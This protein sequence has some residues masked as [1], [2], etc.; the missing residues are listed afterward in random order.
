M[1]KLVGGLTFAVVLLAL[2]WRSTSH[3]PRPGSF[4]WIYRTEI[5]FYRQGIWDVGF[6][7]GDSGPENAGWIVDMANKDD[8]SSL[9]NNIRIVSLTLSGSNL[10]DLSPLE[11]QT[12]L[13]ELAVQ[14]CPVQDLSPLTNLSRLHSLDL[15]GTSIPNVNDLKNLHAL[16]HL[17]LSNT[18]ITDISP[19][20][21]LHNLRS[22][23]VSHTGVTNLLPLAELE[24]LTYLHIDGIPCRDFLGIPLKN[25]RILKLTAQGTVP[26][27]NAQLLHDSF[28]GCLVF[29]FYPNTKMGEGYHFYSKEYALRHF[30]E[31]NGALVSIGSP[32]HEPGVPFKVI[33]LNTQELQ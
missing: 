14:N 24:W 9:S 25:I 20:T 32:P 19:L 29:S 1:K 15:T 6:D 33:P 12:N 8:I 30:D 26:W 31:I 13:C 17:D 18:K 22:L 10:V 11:S 27:K 2:L 23:S 28:N 4:A 3:P 21:E 16:C 5:W 7:E